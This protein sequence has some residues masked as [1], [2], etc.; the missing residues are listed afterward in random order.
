MTRPAGDIPRAAAQVRAVPPPAGPEQGPQPAGRVPPPT[1]LTIPAIGV[2][3]R[4]IQLGI[5][6]S[7]T[8]Q[9]P[10]ITSLAGWYTRSPRPG[11][12]GSAVIAGH[13][14]SAAGPAIFYRLH[15]LRPGER[16]YV[17]QKGG[18]L[19][20]FRVSSVRRYAKARFPAAAVYGPTPV[21]ALRLITCGGTFDPQLGTYLSNVVVYAVLAS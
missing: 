17:Q 19:A 2:R 21:A 1:A 8:L 12:V 11:A 3:S 15:L 13:V 14:D 7:G 20:V 5:T 10:Q 16:I 9:V 18:R 4:L 6:A